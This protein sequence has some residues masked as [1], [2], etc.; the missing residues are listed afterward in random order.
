MTEAQDTPEGDR[1]PDLIDDEVEASRAP[2]LSHLTELRERLIWSFVALGVAFVL[3][4]SVSIPL[5]NFLIVPYVEVVESSSLD[6]EA[7][8]YFAPFEFFFTRI[9]LALMAGFVLAFPVIAYH[10]YAFVAPGLYK[11]ER[12]AVLPFL[13]AM[14]LLF[15]AGAALVYYFIMPFVMN[16]AVGMEQGGSEGG[17]AIELFTK[18]GEY[19]GIITTLFVG[20]GFAFQMPVVLTLCAMAGLISP[21]FL[22]KNRRFAIVGLAC[23]AMLLTPADPFSMI[24]LWITLM[25]LYEISIWAVR[26]V[27]RKR[28]EA[29]AKGEVSPAE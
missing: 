15:T 29:D 13:F 25:G 1:P 10:L 20:F 22:T 6:R 19:L 28:A 7:V 4:F 5:Y 8:L 2:L 26:I 23:A 17:A 24:G 27:V 14:P 3:C 18:V 9:R 16:F 12:K 11:N 21:E